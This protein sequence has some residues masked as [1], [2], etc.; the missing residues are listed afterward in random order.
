LAEIARKLGI[1]KQRLQFVLKFS[2]ST[3]LVPIHCQECGTVITQLR[4]VADNNQGT[5]CLDCLVKHP[6]VTFWQRLKSHRQAL[7]LTLTTLERR[8][9][10]DLSSISA[11][12][13]GRSEPKWQTL[14]KLIRVLG[15]EWL[16]VE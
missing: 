6:E 9:G 2:A 15:V 10:V 16:A 7:G 4:G 11:Y 1:S 12:E 8:S 13:C 5:W 3:R 14:A